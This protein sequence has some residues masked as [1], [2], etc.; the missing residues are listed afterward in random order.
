MSWL[1]KLKLFHTM[2]SLSIRVP[3]TSANLG[4]GFDS[5]GLAFA[6]YNIIR[7][8]SVAQVA[9]ERVRIYT[10]D[11]AALPIDESNITY[12][13]ALRLF[14]YIGREDTSFQLEMWNHIPLSRGL[15]S[16]AAA[17]VGGLVAANE[18]ARAQGWRT[19][20]AAELITLANELEG[21]PDNSSA[22][23]LGGLVASALKT[24]F[25]GKV[26]NEALAVVLPVERYPRFLVWIPDNELPTSQARAVLPTIVPHSDAV[27]NLSR[28]ALLLAAL[29]TGRWELLREALKDRLHQNQRAG[30]LPGWSAVERAA[31]D[32]GAY[33]VTISGAGSSVL[34]WLPENDAVVSGAR[35]AIETAAAQAGVSGRVVSA[36]VDQ[37]G[38][39]VIPGPVL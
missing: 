37:L 33:G 35:R 18:W 2:N 8:S 25:D 39:T 38:A 1:R 10:P 6:F 5:L 19:A 27:F 36:V 14:A 24:G 17:R 9:T 15:G 16:S 7:I 11:A 20:S 31:L 32:E 30:L 34:I 29:S 28:T 26:T 23:L 12:S 13:S 3:A 22:A 4:P 21:H